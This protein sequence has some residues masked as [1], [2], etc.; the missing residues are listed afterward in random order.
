[1]KFKYQVSYI[2]III[3]SEFFPNLFR[4]GLPSG[5]LGLGTLTKGVRDIKNRVTENSTQ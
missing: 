2:F 3:T 5:L 4:F 1:M